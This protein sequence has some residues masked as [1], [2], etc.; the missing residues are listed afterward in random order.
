MRESYEL[1]WLT[2]KNHVKKEIMLEKIFD[3]D[4][5]NPVSVGDFI[6]FEAKICLI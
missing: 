1:A 2:V 3:I 5:T 4:F 6:K